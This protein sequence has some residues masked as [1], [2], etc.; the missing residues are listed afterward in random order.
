MA[1]ELCCKVR[2]D[3]DYVTGESAFFMVY[4]GEAT[5]GTGMGEAKWRIRR[6]TYSGANP[7]AIDWAD[8]VNTF[9]KIWNDRYSYSYS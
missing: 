4:Q 9:N 1:E 3:W 8:G 7:V 6:Y 5:P 2:Y